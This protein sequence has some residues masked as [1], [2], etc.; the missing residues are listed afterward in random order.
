MSAQD[1]PLTQSKATRTGYSLKNLVRN[2][3]RSLVF[4]ERIRVVQC[5]ICA[6]ISIFEAGQMS[7]VM[8]LLPGVLDRSNGREELLTN[9]AFFRHGGQVFKTVDGM[10]S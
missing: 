5:V 4:G 1:N 10:E 8:V 6:S 7:A 2:L 3:C 9:I